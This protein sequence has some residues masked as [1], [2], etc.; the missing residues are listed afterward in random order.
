MSDELLKALDDIREPFMEAM[1][2]SE[3]E[4]EEMW[5]SL[6]HD[7]KLNVFCAV[8]RRIYEGEIEKR[9]SYRYVLYD[10]FKFG[11]EAYVQAQIAGYLS[12]HNAIYDSVT[13]KDILKDFT[14]HVNAE[15]TEEQIDSFLTKRIF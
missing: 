7:E 2:R 4:S 15:V 14:N 5:N 3:E 12:I 13:M 1:K 6:T 8:I 10:V 11:P 9:G